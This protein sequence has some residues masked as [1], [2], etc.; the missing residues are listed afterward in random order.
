ML[1]IEFG[2]FSLMFLRLQE[3]GAVGNSTLV[4]INSNNNSTL[5]LWR[6]W[7]EMHPR[8]FADI[9]RFAQQKLRNMSPPVFWPNQTCLSI[10]VNCV[11]K[12]NPQ[13]L[14]L[15]IPAFRIHSFTLAS[16][17]RPMSWPPSCTSP[18]LPSVGVPFCWGGHSFL[19]LSDP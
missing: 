11:W 4:I 6:N 18:K 10:Y 5:Q 16:N 17:Y 13:G 14:G 8:A 9:L 15:F 19:L 2:C 7:E 1:F 3:K 12:P